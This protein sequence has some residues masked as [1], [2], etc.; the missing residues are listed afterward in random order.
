VQV[1]VPPVTPSMAAT[2]PVVFAPLAAGAVE[3]A[4]SSAAALAR[5]QV[6]VTAPE[7]AT[8]VSLAL[9][10]RVRSFAAPALVPER[11]VATAPE[12][13]V[14]A[15]AVAERK[16]LGL[17]AVRPVLAVKQRPRHKSGMARSVR[18][19]PPDTRSIDRNADTR[20]LKMP[21]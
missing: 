17:A 14:A 11:E 6:L 19:L 13:A 20:L 16:L 4:K 9:T 12:R 2:W 10:K 7:P 3:W 5:A 8:P 1:Q 18:C 15:V 21:P